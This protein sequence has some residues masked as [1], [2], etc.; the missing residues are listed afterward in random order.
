MIYWIIAFI[1]NDQNQNHVHQAM[2]HALF[3][4]KAGVGFE[5]KDEHRHSRGSSGQSNYA[6]FIVL[7]QPS[8]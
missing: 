1:F 8:A 3:G 6:F 7:G 5:V 2:M 4:K